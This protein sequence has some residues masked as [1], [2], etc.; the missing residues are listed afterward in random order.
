MSRRFC[1]SLSLLPALMIVACATP[2][3]ALPAAGD[4]A[5]SLHRDVSGV[6]PILVVTITNRSDKPVCLRAEVLQNPYSYE[7]NLG[8]RDRGRRPVRYY[9]PG[10]LTPPIR[11]NVRL[12][13]GET[14]RGQ[15]FL[16][17]RFR[18]RAAGNPFP[19]GLSARAAFA[20]DYCEDSAPLR[21]TSAWQPLL[22]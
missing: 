13:P 3:V 2:N 22:R 14:G 12:E 11:G 16:D 9:E 6:R 19:S 21:A 8:L 17:A 1:L 18:L 20:Y 5:I 7:M 15:Y 4:L 10:F